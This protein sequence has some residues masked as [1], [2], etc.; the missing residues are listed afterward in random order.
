MCDGE[1]ESAVKGDCALLLLLLCAS[2][3]VALILHRYIGS[4]DIGEIDRTANV[5][6]F[7]SALARLC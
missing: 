4:W 1:C 6:P 3:K 5:G 7:L 2:V